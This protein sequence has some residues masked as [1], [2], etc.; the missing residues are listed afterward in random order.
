MSTELITFARRDDASAAA[1]AGL[2]RGLRQGLEEQ[3]RASLVVSGGTTPGP[4][5]ELLA[6]ET[7]DWSR[8]EVWLSDERWVPSDHADSNERLVRETLL[9]GPAAAAEVCP[10]YEAGQQ[11]AARCDALDA[12]LKTGAVPFSASLLGMGGDGHFAS[13]FPDADNLVP[14][15]AADG[16]SYC[17]PIRTQAS[18]HPRVS[19]T[20]AALI[21]CELIHLLIFGEDKRR[22]V[23][24]A[25]DAKPG[26]ADLP[27]AHL[28]RQLKTPVYVLW[29]P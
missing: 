11:P 24:S 16:E 7:L 6:Q 19:L 5:F 22:V 4:C 23:E 28:L 1:A 10:V 9:K 3:D 2:A 21:Q 20:L 18:P 8:V 17:L 13:L 26:T 25:L 27:V 14:G 15:L 29:A 12:Q